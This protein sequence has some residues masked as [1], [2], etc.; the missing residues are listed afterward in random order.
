MP[1]LAATDR[2]RMIWRNAPAEASQATFRPGFLN[3]KTAFIAGGTSGI[4][5]GIATR[6]TPLG[7]RCAVPGGNPEKAE[8]AAAEIGAGTGVTGSLASTGDVRGHAAGGP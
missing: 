6:H 2:D 8:R 5:L 1:S 7:A 3:G 4:D